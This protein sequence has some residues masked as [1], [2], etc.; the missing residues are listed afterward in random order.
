MQRELGSYG[1]LLGGGSWLWP[2][3]QVGP[4]VVAAG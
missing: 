1:V 3:S 2:F 4:Q